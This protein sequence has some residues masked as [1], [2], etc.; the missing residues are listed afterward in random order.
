MKMEG[1]KRKNT[2]ARRNR[3]RENE[4]MLLEVRNSCDDVPLSFSDFSHFFV[5]KYTEKP[6]YKKPL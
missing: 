3:E 1:K 4:K 5:K 2:R 6:V